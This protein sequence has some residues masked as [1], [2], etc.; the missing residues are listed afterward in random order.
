MCFSL[1]IYNIV[2]RTHYS[3]C[4]LQR[5]HFVAV[6]V[7]PIVWFSL[8]PGYNNNNPAIIIIIIII[9]MVMMMMMMMM[10]IKKIINQKA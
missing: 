1:V 7:A 4:L 3:I 10:I 9:I 2:L 6:N 5:G 8:K